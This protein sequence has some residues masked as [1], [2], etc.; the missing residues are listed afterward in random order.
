MSLPKDFIKRV[1]SRLGKPL[2]YSADCEIL[3]QAIEDATGERLGVTTIKRLFGFAGEKVTPRGTTMDIIAQYL[4]YADMKDMERQLGDA[5]DISMFTAIDEIGSSSLAEGT[6]I[7]ITYSPDRL[8]VLTYIGDCRFI[9]NESQNGKLRK[10]DK[11]RVTHFAKGFE[12]LVSDVVRDGVNLGQ[13]HAAKD[14][15][16]TSLEIIV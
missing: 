8:L 9:V 15:G 11:I 5:A 1:E 12:L 13:Y 3:A 4:G 6:Q 2:K 10:G 16:L 14:G 7:Q